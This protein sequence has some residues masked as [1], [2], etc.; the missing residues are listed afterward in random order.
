M[1][2]L[3]QG[4][5]KLE[6]PLPQQ[7]GLRGGTTAVADDA[8]LRES[9]RETFGEIVNGFEKTDTGMPSYEGV[10]ST[11]IESLILIH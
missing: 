9:I 7:S 8:Y 3:W 4:R 6:R 11:P 5:P 1:V 2:R 10:I